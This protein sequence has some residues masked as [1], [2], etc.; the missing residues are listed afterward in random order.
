MGGRILENE[1]KISN[2]DSAI[3]LHHIIN[4]FPKDMKIHIGFLGYHDV[5]LTDEQWESIGNKSLLEN[6]SNSDKLKSIHS[7]LDVNICPTIKSW[8]NACYGNRVTYD[9]FDFTKYE[10]EEIEHDFNLE[11]PDQYKNKFDIIVDIGTIEHIFNL[12]QAFKNTLLMLK[13]NGYILNHGPLCQPNH[14][15]YGYNPTLFADFY[16]DNGCE[17][18]DM[19]LQS[20]IS[21]NIIAV[22]GLPLFDRFYLSQ[23]YN[24]NKELIGKEFN[25]ITLTKK[26]NDTEE[27]VYPIQRKY[28]NKEQWI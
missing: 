16:M 20:K 15:F 12:P 27:I 8:M 26:V 14:G 5:M 7:R 11:I 1:M 18:V 21:N 10:G 19:V 6:R 9:V 3:I 2:K 25:L 24:I 23:I 4:E 17:I 13:K 28:R 22:E